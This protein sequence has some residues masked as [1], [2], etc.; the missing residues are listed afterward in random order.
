[1]VSEGHSSTQEVLKCWGHTVR[2]S[3]LPSSGSQV[4]KVLHEPF[5]LLT[6]IYYV[7]EQQTLR[8]RRRRLS[9]KGVRPI[10][11]TRERKKP[12]FQRPK[13]SLLFFEPPPPPMEPPK[14]RRNGSM[15]EITDIG[16]PLATFLATLA[17]LHQKSD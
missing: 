6:V 7:G 13:F 14:S 12:F 8:K 2:V 4:A 10:F 11:G 3:V 5:D 1:M 9:T 15:S 17:N 16:D